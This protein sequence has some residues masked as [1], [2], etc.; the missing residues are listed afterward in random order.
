MENKMRRNPGCIL[1]DFNTEHTPR[2]FKFHVMRLPSK[3]S[4]SR[5]QEI[6]HSFQQRWD[7][8]DSHELYKMPFIGQD[9]VFKS[10]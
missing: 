5:P 4:K 7:N 1:Q 8:L 2:P 6:C 9:T 3:Q 10:P